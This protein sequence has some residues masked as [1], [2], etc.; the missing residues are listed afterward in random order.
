MRVTLVTTGNVSTN[1]RL[2]K[3]ADALA[4]AGHAVRVVT[5]D[6]LPENAAADATLIRTR[7]W[8]LDRV[9]I[10][11]GDIVG[12][13][14]RAVSTARQWLAKRWYNDGRRRL[15]PRLADR[16]TSRYADLMVDAAA[17]A[18]ADLVIG[19]N[20]GAL[21]VAVRAAQRLGAR[22]GFDIED[23][24]AGELTDDPRHAGARAVVIDVER[25]YLA[26]C[27]TLTASSPPI[28]DA[29]AAA[30][31]VPRPYVVLNTF[32]RGERDAIPASPP[33]R[34]AGAGRS[35]YWYSQVIGAGR[36]LED[37]IDAL[38]RLDASVRCYLRGRPDPVYVDGLLARAAALGVAD[39]VVLLPPVAPADL[40]PRAAEHDIGLALEQPVSRNRDLCAT[41]KIF[42]YLLAGIAVAATD[43]TGQRW[44]MDAAPGAGFL[45]RSGDADGLAAGLRQLLE[46]P[47][48]LPA[49]RAAAHDA[50]DRRFNFEAEAAGLV[51]YLESAMR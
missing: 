51:A 29:I 24:H 14:R 35:L 15:T 1:P 27:A 17:A 32:P 6:A 37:V 44:V 20:L 4:A 33:D 28:A 26:A 49:A 13:A 16:I 12:F 42:T 2:V 48:A 25:R 34:P 43:T 8:P 7:S 10:R 38:P 21:P 39:R 47:G 50:A 45:Y 31:G 18:P 22:A 11:H 30:Y 19:H 3:E 40:V 41:N 9:N 5:M 23:F 46:T 36:G